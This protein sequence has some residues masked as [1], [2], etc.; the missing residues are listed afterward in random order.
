MM[1]HTPSPIIVLFRQDLRLKDNPALA[2]ACKTGLPIIPLY[3][4]DDE[5]PGKWKM[6]G[7]SRWWLHHSLSSLDQSLQKKGSELFLYKGETLTVL[8]QLIQK[9]Q[10]S[11]I[12]WNR[13]YEPYAIQLEKKIKNLLPHSQSFNGSLLFEPWE[14][15]NK[16][17]QPFKVFTPFWHRC[18]EVESIDNP[19]AEPAS[20]LT[21]KIQSDTLDSWNLLP[22][23]P[24]WAEGLRKQWSIGE[25]AAQ[26]KLNH[27]ISQSLETYD[28]GRDFPSQSTTSELSPHLHFGEISP[29]QL[30][31]QTKNLA[32]SKKFLSELGWREFSYYQLFH[33]PQLPEQPWRPEFSKFPWEINSDF[34]KRQKPCPNRFY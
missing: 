15:F 5:N 33:F 31:Y 29:R 18:M 34:L 30:F 32:K 26:T 2:Y 1:T 25:K 13:C 4:L 22:T 19:L 17:N 16:Q 12:F 24:D 11:G 28:H 3:I 14:I 9:H 8:S 21:K 27:F 10:V 20:I 23:H 7:A 6:G